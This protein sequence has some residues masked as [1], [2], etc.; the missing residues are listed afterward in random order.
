MPIFQRKNFVTRYL[1]AAC[2]YISCHK[3]PFNINFF[4]YSES[5]ALYFFIECLNLKA[6]PKE[7]GLWSG[8]HSRHLWNL[9]KLQDLKEGRR[10]CRNERHCQAL[11]QSGYIILHY[12]QQR[13]RITVVSHLFPHLFG[14]LGTGLYW[15]KKLLNF[16][17]F[18]KL[19]SK[20]S[21]C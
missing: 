8:F 15:L 13:M 3:S 1:K 6:I 4:P 14:E 20:H 11:F 16:Q 10:E 7:L 5:H 2:Q 9:I 18:C 19:V 12:Y 17:E 21:H